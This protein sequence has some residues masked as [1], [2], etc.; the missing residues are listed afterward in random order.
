MNELM[1]VAN[2]PAPGHPL[3]E[4]CFGKAYVCFQ[5]KISRHLTDVARTAAAAAAGDSASTGD[6]ES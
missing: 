3:K 1:A 4:R 2:K 6:S 5:R